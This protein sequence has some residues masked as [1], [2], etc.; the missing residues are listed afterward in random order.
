MNAALRRIGEEA[1]LYRDAETV[2][3]L[4]IPDDSEFMSESVAGFDVERNGLKV[5]TSTT[6]VTHDDQYKEL[7]YQ[8]QRYTIDSLRIE[9]DEAELEL[10]P[11]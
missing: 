11:C 3:I 10:L 8:G 4:L 5:L 2:D 1:T 9:L 7:E 6:H